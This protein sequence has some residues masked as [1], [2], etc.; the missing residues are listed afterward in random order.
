[1]RELEDGERGEEEIGKGKGKMGREWGG[2]DGK[3]QS[4]Q[5][6]GFP[7]LSLKGW[8]GQSLPPLL[9]PQLPLDGS[10]CSYSSL[11]SWRTCPPL[12][13]KPRDGSGFLP[14]AAPGNL[15]EPLSH[16]SAPQSWK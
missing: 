10:S 13:F 12:S 15:P 14:V 11:G 5:Q 16:K 2:K 1:M 8:A 4:R 3:E 6:H 7:R 9:R